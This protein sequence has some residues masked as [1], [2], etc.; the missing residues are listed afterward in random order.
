M[1]QL[2]RP[3]PDVPGPGEESVWNYPRPPRLEQT[4]VR[5]EVIFGGE[6]IAVTDAAWRVLETSHP[7]N[8]YLPRDAFVPGA[9]VPAGGGSVCE[10]KGAATYWTLRGGGAE[11]VAAGWSYEAPTS[12]YSGLRG[13][14]ALYA[15]RMDGCRVDGELV[16]PQPGNFYGGWITAA[17][18]GPFKGT[19]GSLGW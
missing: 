12:A 3:T 16:T 4:S 10:W 17:I 1:S 18:K 14:L 15:G 11:A 5:I 7:P 2:A 6:L 9:I 19:P 13:H 8:Y